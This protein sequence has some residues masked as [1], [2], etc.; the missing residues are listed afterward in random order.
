MGGRR[1]WQVKEAWVREGGKKKIRKKE[2]MGH[3]LQSRGMAWHGMAC[4]CLIH[5][6][7]ERSETL[8]H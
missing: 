6:G 2:S 5:K 3:S 4:L 7:G 8:Q 1:L